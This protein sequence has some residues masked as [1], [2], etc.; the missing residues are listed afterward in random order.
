MG[1]CFSPSTL[2]ENLSAST[3]PRLA[4]APG[5]QVGLLTGGFDRPYAFGLAMA[6]ISTGVS[7]DVIASTEL[8]SPE[9]HATPG[10]NF[11]N[12]QGDP[13]KKVDPVWKLVR[14][15]T[16]YVKLCRYAAT[17]RPRIFH[18][19]WNNKIQFLDRTLLMLYYKLLGKKIVLTVHNVNAGQRDGN[20]SSLNRFTLK[21]QYRLA[22]HI[23]VH[24]GRM[25]GQ[26]LEEFGVD[27]RAVTVIPFGINNSVPNTEL[28]PTQARQ[29][30]GVDRRAKTILFFGAIRPYK[31]L[32]H[33]VSAFHEIAER[34]P[35]Y[36]LV[37]AGEPRK[38][39]A[40]YLRNVLARIE[41]HPSRT[42]V[43][44]RL[45]MVP[46]SETEVYFKAADVVALP[47][48]QIFQSGV[49]FLAFRFGLPVL[50]TDIGPFRDDVI[51]GEN[52]FLSD[53]G[54]QRA[55]ART[56]E[57]YFASDL[58]KQLD[59]RRNDIRERAEKTHSWELVASTT[60]GVY[61]QL[62]VQ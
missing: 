58:Y 22:D 25:K 19:L 15:L 1:A 34:D 9:M 17:A 46:D 55:L 28:T 8:E 36:R 26:L 27:R 44:R 54:N 35:D 6:L 23:F 51:E 56:I 59:A 61:E 43:I 53:P 5:L 2:G 3:D 40:E 41:S 10:V 4:Q 60:R 13:Q 18:I 29:R 16:F 31:G 50:A 49:M 38:E 37:I 48:V 62:L 39:C 47:Y 12:L 45:E 33:L 14:L 21:I 42:Q 7:L 32:E 20:D 30:L 11:L 24:T 57:R 52:G